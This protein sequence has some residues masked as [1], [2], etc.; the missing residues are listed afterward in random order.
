MEAKIAVPENKGPAAR[1]YTKEQRDKILELVDQACDVVNYSY[2]VTYLKTSTG[3]TD[4]ALTLKDENGKTALVYTDGI[5]KA[6]GVN[7]SA[8]NLTHL[9]LVAGVTLILAAGAV[10]V[11]RKKASEK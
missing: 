10:V 7:D 4:W 5:V 3:G 11:V 9:W 6:T 8:S 2:E 1:N